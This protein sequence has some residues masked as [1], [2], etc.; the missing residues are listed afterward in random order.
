M[1]RLIK[2][3]IVIYSRVSTDEQVTVGM[4]LQEQPGVAREALDRKFG[5]GN[6]EIVGEFSDPG[7]S[8][9]SGPT[10]R[11]VRDG[12]L[13]PKK[14]NRP[15]LSAVFELVLAGKVDYV[16]CI[17]P[18]RL[19][20][21]NDT[22]VVLER[23][24]LE[25]GV[26][27]VCD[28]D[29]LDLESPSGQ[30]MAGVVGAVHSYQ[31]SSN[32]ALIKQMI[33]RRKDEGKATGTAP[34]GWRHP[35][36]GEKERGMATLVPIHEQLEAVRQ[37]KDLYLRGHSEREIA[38]KLNEQGVAFLP[39]KVDNRGAKRTEWDQ[40]RVNIVLKNIV[41]AGYV[42]DSKGE[43]I[44]GLHFGARAYDYEDYRRIKE[45]MSQKRRRPVG[46]KSER[47]EMALTGIPKCGSCG[48]T[49]HFRHFGGYLHFKCQGLRSEERSRHVMVRA[50]ILEMA[51][52]HEVEKLATSEETK[53][54]ARLRIGMEVRKGNQDAL[55]EKT[56]LETRK[57]KFDDMEEA[58][59]RQL[60]E[61]TLKEGMFKRQMD[62]IEG[63]RKE[64]ESRLSEITQSLSS[65]A[66]T[67]DLERRAYQALESFPTVWAHLEP[68]ERK[69]LME[70]VLE[71][72][73][74]EDRGGHSVAKI[75][76]HLLAEVV[77]PLPRI[78]ATRGSQGGGVESLTESEL[79]ALWHLADGRKP[80]EGASLMRITRSTFSTLT[81]RGAQRM[82]ESNPL[83]AA[84]RAKPWMTRIAHLLPLYEHP[85]AKLRS[86][87]R[88][89]FIFATVRKLAS[90]G[91]TPQDISDQIGIDLGRVEEALRDA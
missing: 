62:A 6:Y 75:K 41:H 69:R 7:W 37:V 47:P 63:E 61:E 60:R 76:V 2:P 14:G 83:K 38:R 12:K 52:L 59:L 86:T 3:R 70:T 45:L 16:A 24:F 19:Y 78:N 22:N 21:R 72:L 57:A 73:I 20:R 23:V 42:T 56:S 88:A 51:V 55:T 46:I 27:I 82:G 29:S 64:V 77:V 44:K 30:L 58:A 87:K 49:L 33:G 90:D 26:G 9:N 74:V 85:R 67:E 10:D 36:A 43:H 39:K 28:Q 50:N 53:R 15:G 91:L 81:A 13:I 79:A 71:S 8:G 17:N 68:S 25:H 18:S 4:S 66:R 35:T 31:R 54:Q 84:R 40:V 89:P 32:N 1:S 48:A 80:S 5:P 11:D 65:V 34:Y